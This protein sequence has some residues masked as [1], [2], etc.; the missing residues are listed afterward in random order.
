[1]EDGIVRKLYRNGLLNVQQEFVKDTHYEV[2]TGSTSY[3]MSDGGSDTD[4]VGI[5]V[6]PVDWVFPHTV[7]HINGFGPNPNKF[8]VFQQHHIMFND[9]EYDIA[10]YGIVKFFQLAS[11]NNPN[12]CDLLFVPDRLIVHQ[13]NIGRLI[14]QNRK[15]FLTR[16]SFHKFTG[17]AYAQLKKMRN[18]TRK[19]SRA[20]LFE[21]FGYDVKYAAHLIRLALEC[22]QILTEHDLDL[23]RHKELLKAVRRGEWTIDQIES[24]FKNKEESL[25]KMYTESTLRYGPD[26][27]ELTRVL[28]CCLEEKYGSISNYVSAGAD[29]RILRKYEQIVQIINS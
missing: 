19:E 27:E 23:E 4:V 26:W 2:I 24:W 16:H 21:K 18:M 15:L 20:D 8:D 10:V 12:I 6:P 25:N 28:M 29:P 3:G 9:K 22:E 14:R 17:Y 7:G 13:D 11:E 5:C 1:V